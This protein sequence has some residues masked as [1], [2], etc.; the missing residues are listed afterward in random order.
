M[1]VTDEEHSLRVRDASLTMDVVQTLYSAAT[2]SKPKSFYENVLFEYA[3]ARATEQND[4][5]LQTGLGEPKFYLNNT[6]FSGC[7]TA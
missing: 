6:I 3:T 2:K 7:A 5:G 1:K 4:P